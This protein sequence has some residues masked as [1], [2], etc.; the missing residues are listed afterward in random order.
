MAA[1]R[2]RTSKVNDVGVGIMIASTLARGCIVRCISRMRRRMQEP[3]ISGAL[4]VFVSRRF[5][6]PQ[7]RCRASL[8]R[9]T[10]PSTHPANVCLTS[11]HVSFNSTRSIGLL[12]TCLAIFLQQLPM[13]TPERPADAHE[14]C[15]GTSPTSRRTYKWSALRDSERGSAAW[16]ACRG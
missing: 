13:N 14:A 16:L 2:K 4:G 3:A 7:W 8:C 5:I 15:S 10:T 1:A 11:G 9:H 6:F 12:R